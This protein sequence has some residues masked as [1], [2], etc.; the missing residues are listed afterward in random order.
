MKN[1]AKFLREANQ[2][3]VDAARKNNKETI[4]VGDI[5]GK[6]FFD[7]LNYVG[8]VDKLSRRLRN[9]TNKHPLGKIDISINSPGGMVWGEPG[10]GKVAYLMDTSG[11]LSVSEITR[12]S[13]EAML[14]TRYPR[15]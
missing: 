12:V 5:T 6:V 9:F 2:K 8:D 3:R 10:E 11:I 7:E 13:A 1:Y 14:L 4:D 15:R